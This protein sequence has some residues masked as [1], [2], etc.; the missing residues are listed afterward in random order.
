MKKESVNMDVFVW[1]RKR[2]IKGKWMFIILIDH[3]L[4]L[5]FFKKFTLNKI[6]QHL[7]I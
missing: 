5:N 1:F 6:I 3:E 2:Q 4:L 7:K